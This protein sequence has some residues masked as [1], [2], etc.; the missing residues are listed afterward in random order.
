MK[1]V[2][3]GTGN[4]ATVVGKLIVSK[5]HSIV[6][7]VGRNNLTTQLLAQVLDAKPN[8]DLKTINPN[9]DLYIIAV[10]DN[11]I[12]AIAEELRLENKLVVHTAGSVAIGKL[13]A[14]SN[15]YGV[16]WPLQTIRKEV[17]TTPMIPFVIDAN[18]QSAYQLLHAFASTLSNQIKMANDE[19]RVKMHLAAVVVSNFSNHLFALANDYC[20]QEAL[21]F[22][23]LLPLMQE[24]I[25]KIKHHQPHSV[26]TGPAVRND[27]ITIA[28]HEDLLQQ[29]QSLQ[30]LYKELS[31]SIISYQEKTTIK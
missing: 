27:T 30:H 23:M 13:K 19:K 3:I 25:E 2:I 22:S 9:A 24:T 6:E 12:K 31:D 20:K 28:K 5:G 1:V 4:V 7:V 11:A 10:A 29:H 8:N 18:T 15:L 14:S 16:L 17:I 21:D 26:Q